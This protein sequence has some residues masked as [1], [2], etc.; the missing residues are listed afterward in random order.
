MNMDISDSSLTMRR[1]LAGWGIVISLCL[2]EL[3]A[4]LYAQSSGLGALPLVVGLVRSMGEIIPSIANIS[5]C[6]VVGTAGGFMIML[7]MLFFPV[8]L[9]A[10]Y[11]A[12]PHT[13]PTPPP[14]GW[15]GVWSMFYGFMISLATLVPTLMWVLLSPTPTGLRSLDARL[16]ALCAGG[17]PSFVAATVQ[18]GFALLGAFCSVMILISIFRALRA[19]LLVLVRENNI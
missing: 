13:N 7:N 10:I 3:W 12:H 15:K 1:R 14:P 17:L 19:R 2:V 4:S 6:S 16:S 8:K 11:F 18:G 5:A 9:T